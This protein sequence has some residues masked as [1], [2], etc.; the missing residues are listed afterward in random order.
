[1]FINQNVDK[2]EH[3][4]SNPI[5]IDH[6]PEFLP[7]ADKAST[8]IINNIKKQYKKDKRPIPNSYHSNNMWNVPGYKNLT[9]YVL[10]K[11]FDIMTSWGYKTKGM[12]PM[13]SELWVQEFPKEGGFH[14]EHIHSNNHVSGFYFLRCSPKTSHPVFHDPR[15]TKRMT[16][17]REE[18]KNKITQASQRI[19][20]NVKPGD[21]LFFPSY[22]PHSY[23]HHKGEE[24]FRFVH[25][26]MQLNLPPEPVVDPKK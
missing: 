21:F 1:M 17:L 6:R 18:D 24:I 13:L 10:Q 19:H 25:F 5:I 23:V 14:D 26:N 12:I 15:F 3:I 7:E 4:F 16:D 22:M 9:N 11:S 8:P 20:F 2:I